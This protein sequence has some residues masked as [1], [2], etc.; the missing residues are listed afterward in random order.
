MRVGVAN[1]T[2]AIALVSV[3]KLARLYGTV[4][5][6]NEGIDSVG[7]HAILPTTIHNGAL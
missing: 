7:S 5:E 2:C 6:I 4:S 1:N 3:F